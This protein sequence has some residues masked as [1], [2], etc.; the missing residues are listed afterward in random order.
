MR[1]ML[2]V[3]LLL[4]CQFAWAQKIGSTTITGHAS[5]GACTSGVTSGPLTVIVTHPRTSGVSPFVAFFDATA[6][7][8]SSVAN[9]VDQDVT[10][11]W[12][13]GDG[14]SVS[15]SGASWLYGSNGTANG[16]SGN[17]RNTGT[18]ISPAHLYFVAD[19][20]G[21][22]NYTVTLSAT[23][24]TNAVTCTDT[25][26]AYDPMGA[27]GYSTQV[28]QSQSGNFTLC[29]VG[30]THSTSGTAGANLS[31]SMSSKRVLFACGDTF[32]GSSTWGGTK[33]AIGAY[34]GCQN[35][36][37]NRPIFGG[38][39]SD[40]VNVSYNVVNA[41]ISDLDFESSGGAIY[42]GFPIS[43]AVSSGITLYNLK[44]VGNPI[45]Y[46]VQ[47]STQV[48]L[49]Q[50]YMFG[51]SLT[52]NPGTQGVYIQDGQNN[53]SNLTSGY[54]C[55]TGVFQNINYVALMGSHFDG[56][57][58]AITDQTHG[59][60]TVRTSAC[61]MCS[62]TN[63]DF[64]NANTV[65]AVLKFHNGNTF[66]TSCSWTGQPTEHIQITDNLFTGTS[67]GQLVENNPQNQ[68]TDERLRYFVIER[69]VFK[70]IAGTNDALSFSVMYGTVR[71]NAFNKTTDGVMGIH[72]GNRGYSGTSN[73]TGG[74]ACSGS[75][76]TSAPVLALYPQFNEIYN[77]SF[78]GSGTAVSFSGG[79]EFNGGPGNNS[80]AQNNLVFGG[81]VSS[82]TGSNNTIG[83]NTVTT[84]NN[85]GFTN[86]SGT[87]NLITDWKPTAN[88]SGAQNNVPVNYDALGNPW[89]PT[90]DLG[91]VH[92]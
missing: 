87:L 54:P 7:T 23:D 26:T 62:Y 79:D 85:P 28:C 70:Q 74:S 21:D 6:T 57:G 34:G 61:R 4:F 17:S 37:T 47:Q 49:V 90:W 59:V 5:G 46:Y 3:V 8:D 14:S 84:S 24:G 44:S 82:N 10:F 32:S 88:Y 36:L 15:G 92:H 75:G 71:D 53:C 50:D 66:D 1:K 76:T 52:A 41:T 29:P 30:A 58:S 12:T 60:E 43:G 20:A 22:Q 80:V 68:V 2:A 25:V 78:D 35:T 19:G 83:S 69:N 56:N 73:N 72:I 38:S 48:A 9:S 63:N 51:M 91:A 55:A 86:G 40:P 16:G 13:F 65:G 64:M 81:S 45:S 31:T 77:N 27:N 42:V 89:A 18:G 67:G 39:L 33:V 11:T